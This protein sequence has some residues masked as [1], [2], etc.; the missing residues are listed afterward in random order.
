MV[1]AGGFPGAARSRGR[2]STTSVISYNDD[3][4]LGYETR[5]DQT[6]IPPDP[7]M[8]LDRGSGDDDNTNHNQENDQDDPFDRIFYGQHYNNVVGNLIELE[9][10]MHWKIG[11]ITDRSRPWGIWTKSTTTTTTTEKMELRD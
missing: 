1:F 8:P 4:D 10:P 9:L 6:P 5:T 11:C 3:D 7:G 2:P